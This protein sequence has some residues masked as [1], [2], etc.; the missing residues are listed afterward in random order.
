MNRRSIAHSVLGFVLLAGLINDGHAETIR[1]DRDPETV[2]LLAKMPPARLANLPVG[3]SITHTTLHG[4]KQ[5]GVEL[6]RIDN[7]KLAITVI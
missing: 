6:V 2:D 4:G 1:V 7:E 3:G 5:E